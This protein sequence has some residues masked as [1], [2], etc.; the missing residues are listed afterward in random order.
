MIGCP[1]NSLKAQEIYCL[2]PLL[3]ANLIFI[4]VCKRLSVS[5]YSENLKILICE[6][7]QNGFLLRGIIIMGVYA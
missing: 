6:K 1:L 7:L 3:L 5:Q 2:K 4:L